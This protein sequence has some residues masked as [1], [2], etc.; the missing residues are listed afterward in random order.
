MSKI[1]SPLFAA[2]A[3]CAAAIAAPAAAQ[4]A[5]TDIRKIPCSDIDKWE[6]ADRVAAIFFFYGFHAAKMDIYEV[7][8]ANLERNVRNIVEFCGKNPAMPLYEATPKA[9]QR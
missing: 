2:L 1:R 5:K 8:P 9:F 7:T 4:D 3:V 6:D